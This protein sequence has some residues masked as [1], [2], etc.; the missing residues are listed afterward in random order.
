MLNFNSILLFSQSPKELAEFYAKVFQTAPGW[1]QSDYSGWQVGAGYFMVGPHDQVKGR[2]QN[3]ERMMI[4]YETN[5][6]AGEFARI[7]ALGTTVVAKPYHP[8]EEPE[9]WLA[10]FADPDGNYFQL[11]TP[12]KM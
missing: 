4:N 3:P 12:M 1:T 5:D 11:A 2:N 6:V 7:E 9:M 10:T 8:G